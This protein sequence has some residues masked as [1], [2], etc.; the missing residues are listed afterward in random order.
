MRVTIFNAIISKLKELGVFT[1]DDG[2]IRVYDYPITAPAG[3]P[4]VV[5]AP[6]TLISEELDNQRDRR[7]YRYHL[8][9]IGEKFGEEAGNK[10][11]A[12][13]LLA[14]QNVED[15]VLAAFDANADLSTSGVIITR[16]IQVE[17]GYAD[18]GSRVVLDIILDVLTT[19]NITL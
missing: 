8:Q 14:M 10:T 16:P 11:Q 9:V 19:V 15:T 6:N 18:N 1:G 17:W 2:T 4:Y 13:A 12:E 7:T 3:Y 5:V